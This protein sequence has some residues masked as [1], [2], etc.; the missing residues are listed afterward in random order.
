M[1]TKVAVKASYCSCNVDEDSQSSVIGTLV[2]FV[3]K[4]DLSL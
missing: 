4:T 1:A 2:T 3:F